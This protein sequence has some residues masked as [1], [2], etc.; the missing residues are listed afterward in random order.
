MKKKILKTIVLSILPLFLL[1]GCTKTENKEN[2]S[3]SSENKMTVV[4]TTAMIGDVASEI[5]KERVEVYSM[6]GPGVDPHLYKAKTSDLERL[7]SSD[8]II[9]NGIHLEAKMADVLEK[10]SSTKNIHSIEEGLDENNLITIEQAHDPHIW[11]DVQNWITASKIIRDALTS[12]DPDGKEIYQANYESYIAKLEEL[13]S[14]VKSQAQKVPKEQRILITAHDA[15][16]YF[17]RAYDFEVKG[18]QGI[19]TVDE[20]GTLDVRNLAQFITDNKIKA[21]FVESSV[22]PKSIQALQAAVES[23][24]WNII[25]GGEL[26]SDAMGDANTFEGTYIGMVT[27]NIDTIVSGLLGEE[28]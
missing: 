10:L 3:F 15:F 13:D 20:A 25:I 19:S 4:T 12:T 16:N 23:R 7:T 14:Y 9:Y 21:L 17:G 2:A 1:I 18:L 22:S 5:G 27:H 11:F 24:G 26:Y 6:M 28:E 8:L